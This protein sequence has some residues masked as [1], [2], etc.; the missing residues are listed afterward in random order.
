[1]LVQ[2]VNIFTLAKERLLFPLSFQELKFNLLIYMPLQN[3]PQIIQ[4]MPSTLP[5]SA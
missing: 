2:T 3:L 1:M 5:F 4:I